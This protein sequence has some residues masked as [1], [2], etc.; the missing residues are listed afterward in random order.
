MLLELSLEGSENP[1]FNPNEEQ[2]HHIW[3]KIGDEVYTT[4]K[5][6][7]L[8][9]WKN[10]FCLWNNWKTLLCI[11]VSYPLNTYSVY[12]DMFKILYCEHANHHMGPKW[13]ILKFI[14]YLW[15]WKEIV[16]SS[17]SLR[18]THP[19]LIF[20]RYCTITLLFPLWKVGLIV[21]ALKDF[22]IQKVQSNV[23]RSVKYCWKVKPSI[24][25]SIL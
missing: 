9:S 13:N 6:K 12:F 8:K 23:R 20:L 14:F 10:I 25:N 19:I 2:A 5:F 24:E 22:H 17:T 18:C 21:L 16:C 11:R 15:N 7:L 4:M 1:E 3:P